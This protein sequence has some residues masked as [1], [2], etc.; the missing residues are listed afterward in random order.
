MQPHQ[1]QNTSQSGRVMQ[2]LTSNSSM[3]VRPPKNIMGSHKNSFLVLLENSNLIRLNLLALLTNL[4][5]SIIII[6]NKTRFLININKSTTDF[7]VAYEKKSKGKFEVPDKKDLLAKIF[8]SSLDC[9]G[10]DEMNISLN[11]QID[12]INNNLSYLN[13]ISSSSKFL[14]W[15]GFIFSIIETM[16]YNKKFNNFNISITDPGFID[17]LLMLNTGFIISL[18]SHVFYKKIKKDCQKYINRITFFSKKF[19]NNIPGKHSSDFC[20]DSCKPKNESCS[21]CQKNYYKVK[22]LERIIRNIRENKGGNRNFCSSFI[23]D[24]DD[25]DY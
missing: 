24:S 6:V 19:L 22:E 10:N 14:G 3:M 5:I 1:N 8:K 25:S 15:T 4:F 16:K 2:N 20:C 7:E 18:P 13:I 12:I 9:S 21:G 17:A 11:K 23:N